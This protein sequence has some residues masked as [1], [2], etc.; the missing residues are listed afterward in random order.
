MSTQILKEY[1]KILIKNAVIVNFDSRINGDILIEE[2]II[3]SIKNSINLNDISNSSKIKIIDAKGNYI[4]PG[5]IDAHTHP[6]LPEDLGFFKGTDDFETETHA[7]MMGGTTTIVDF[8]EQSKGEKLIDALNKRKARYKSSQGSKFTFHSAITEVKDDIFSQLKEIKN[9]GINSVKLY[10]TY[11]MKLCNE[12]ILKVMDC[13]AKLDMVVLVHCEEDS[14]IQ[15]CADKEFY[16]ETRPAEAEQNM[17]NTIINFS[18]ITNCECYICHVSS[19]KSAE[20]IMKAKKVGVRVDFETCP[21]YLLFDDSK[22]RL[23]P[24]EMVKFILSPPF[25]KAE[26]NKILIDACKDGYVDL[27]STDHCAFL[28]EEHKK[29]YCNDIN[30][31]AK[32]IPGIQLRPSLMYDLLVVKNKLK[33]ED[34]VKLLSY[35]PARILKLVDR[36]YLKEGKIADLVIWQEEKFM[37]RK[38]ML[39][40]GTD[41]SPYEGMEIVGRPQYVIVY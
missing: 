12:D 36:G 22:Y 20:I 29:K 5:F 6:G 4:F 26:D 19:G 25:R 24:E 18:K 39:L 27:I 31:A 34:F 17:V 28:Y 37:V 35:N 3:K 7:A 10:S 9:E 16:E 40:E 32:G 38:E 11:G 1:N 41:Y 33:L 8:A 15:Y 23:E 30:K 2:G 13:C 14:I 21:Q